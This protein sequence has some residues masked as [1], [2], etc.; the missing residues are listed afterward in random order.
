MS[1]VASSNAD[2]RRRRRRLAGTVKD[3]LREL[4][5][6]LSL[7]N[8]HI[9]GRVALRGVDFD[10]L[11]MIGQHGPL[12]PSALAHRAGLHPATITGIVDRLEK[13]GWV[14]RERHP[15]DRR[16]VVIRAIPGR[17]AE[18][19][20]LYAGMNASLDA[21]CAEYGDDQLEVIAD[22]LRR[23]TEAGRAAADDL[24]DG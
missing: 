11:D 19:F 12:S 15:T 7:L 6:Q 9:G 14:T 2:E 8:H 13:G 3:A 4:N 24:A 21:L 17:N 23:T 18:L 22:F 5:L 16:A 10:C 1:S 20:R